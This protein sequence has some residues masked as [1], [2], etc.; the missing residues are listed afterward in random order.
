VGSATW[1]A[2]RVRARRSVARMRVRSVPDGGDCRFSD[3][4]CGGKCLPQTDGTFKCQTACVAE[5]GR[6]TTSTDCCGN[7]CDPVTQT[8]KPPVSTCTPLGGSCSTPADCCS[9]LCVNGSC[10]ANVIVE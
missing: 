6:C 5:S 1:W 10:Y 4:C 7:N 3:Q 9:S 2:K 8:C